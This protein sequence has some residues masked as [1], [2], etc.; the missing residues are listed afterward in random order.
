[1]A[2]L[3]SLPRLLAAVFPSGRARWVWQPPSGQNVLLIFLLNNLLL[4][5]FLTYFLFS[6]LY[7]SYIFYIILILILQLSYFSYTT[8]SFFYL[9]RGICF[10]AHYKMPTG[11]TVPGCWMRRTGSDFFKCVTLHTFFATG[12]LVLESSALNTRWTPTVSAI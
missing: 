10:H 6:K 3:L 7:L 5:S 12:V 8:D 9:F 4:H 11:K 2:R 1:M